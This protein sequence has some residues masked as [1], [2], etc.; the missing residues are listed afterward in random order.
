MCYTEAISRPFRV[1]FFPDGDS[2]PVREHLRGLKRSPD[3]KAAAARLGLDLR[4]LQEEGL[5]SKQISIRRIAGIPGS[6][7][8]LRRPFEGIQYR[9]YFYV[10]DGEIWLLHFLEKKSPRIPDRDLDL[11]R[12]RAKEVSS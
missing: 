2:G 12:R 5:A 4:L 6:V 3:R 9:I 10:G 7:W 11:I 1:Q 8:E